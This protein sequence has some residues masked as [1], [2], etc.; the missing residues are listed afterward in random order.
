M[1]LAERIEN[2]VIAMYPDATFLL[3]SDFERD[4]L[5][6]FATSNTLIVLNN[7][8]DDEDKIVENASFLIKERI[9]ISVYLKDEFDTTD[10]MANDLVEQAKDISRRI[11]FRI[12]LFHEVSGNGVT[13]RPAIKVFN[14]IRSGCFSL[15][16]WSYS[17]VIHCSDLN[18]QVDLSAGI[19]GTTV[20][21]PGIYPKNYEDTM[22][23]YGLASTGYR[24][25]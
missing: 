8:L 21:A 23:I 9:Q 24:F 20:P 6:Y 12:W 4:Y 2:L 17:S 3:S 19:G 15:A 11:Y 13:H 5:S 18:L 25:Y 22:P 10:K 7:Q 16:T 14:S 1:T